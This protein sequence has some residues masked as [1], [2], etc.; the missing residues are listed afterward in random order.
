MSL[1]EDSQSVSVLESLSHLLLEHAM[2]VKSELEVKM[3]SETKQKKIDQLV[4]LAEKVQALLW[5]HPVGVNNYMNER[6]QN[7]QLVL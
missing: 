1:E 2:G 4:A 6:H 7:Y 5:G 3:E